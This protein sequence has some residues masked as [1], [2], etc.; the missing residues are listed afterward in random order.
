MFKF[1]PLSTNNPLHV[2]MYHHVFVD[3]T[4]V[5]IRGRQ[6][7]LMT[8]GFLIN[9]Y[10]T[11]PDVHQLLDYE[12][13]IDPATYDVTLHFHSFTLAPDLVEGVRETWLPPQ[14]GVIVLTAP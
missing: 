1:H 4:T 10:A 3:Q 6:H 2:R 5:I 14:T 11:V 9:V 8:A 12:S 13:I 7:G